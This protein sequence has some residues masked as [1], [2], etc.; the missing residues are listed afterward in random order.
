MV[1]PLAAMSLFHS[2]STW[3]RNSDAGAAR[4]MRVSAFVATV[5]G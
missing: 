5:S 2:A 4:Q 1:R 3:A